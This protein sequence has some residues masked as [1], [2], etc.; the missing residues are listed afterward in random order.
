[1]LLLLLH[2]HK[3]DWNLHIMTDVTLIEFLT[4]YLVINSSAVE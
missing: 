4:Q 1:M 3:Q 2:A